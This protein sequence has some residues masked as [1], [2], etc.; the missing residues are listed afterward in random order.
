[1]NKQRNKQNYLTVTERLNLVTITT[2]IQFDS[3][4]EKSNSLKEISY[5]QKENTQNKVNLA[6]LPCI[7][8]TS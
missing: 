6:D 3:I 4:T 2:R 5:S 8:Y 1:M 7:S